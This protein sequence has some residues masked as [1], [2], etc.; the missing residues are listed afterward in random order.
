M[1]YLPPLTILDSH[2][3]QRDNLPLL[4]EPFPHKC[5]TGEKKVMETFK[6]SDVQLAVWLETDTSPAK[7]LRTLSSKANI[8]IVRITNNMLELLWM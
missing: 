4:E 6:L 7:Y 5:K 2:L 3:A 8:G 1:N